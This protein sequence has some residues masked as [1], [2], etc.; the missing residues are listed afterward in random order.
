MELSGR[1]FM[2]EIDIARACEYA[3]SCQKFAAKRC[4]P[5]TLLCLW[6]IG[7]APAVAADRVALV[8]GNSTYQHVPAL[9]NPENDA[10]AVA[11]LL[12]EGGF[13]RVIYRTNVTRL[14]LED[15]VD[16]FSEVVES[17]STALFFY[18]GHG[19]QVDGENYIIPVDASID[20]RRDIRKLTTIGEVLHEVG[21]ARELGVVI[22][23]ACRDNPFDEAITRSIG[24]GAT[25]RGLSPPGKVGGN[26]LVAYATEA[27]GVAS[28]GL[29]G[30]VNSPYTAALLNH[31]ATPGEDIRKIFGRVRDDVMASTQSTQRPFVYGSLGGADYPL[32]PSAADPAPAPVT[33]KPEP[34]PVQQSSDSQAIELALWQ[35]A[36]DGNTAAEYQAYLTRFPDGIFAVSAR[37]RLE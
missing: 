13:S 32:F 30:E 1:K 17:A 35:S 37:D 31:L 22:L 16:E 21:L 7:A 12:R 20:G 19:I 4:F 28:D 11:E 10:T 6:L 25:S 23:D 14:E 8:I 36:A 18:A 2:F 27:H 34:K 15:A 26:T 29:E 24:A 9:I 3:G 33:P 5:I